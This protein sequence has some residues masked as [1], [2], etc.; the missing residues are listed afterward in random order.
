M[1]I[2]TG[3]CSA[4]LSATLFQT[5]GLVPSTIFE[6]RSEG[7]VYGYAYVRSLS[8]HSAEITLIDNANGERLTGWFFADSE[9]TADTLEFEL[10][11]DDDPRGRFSFTPGTYERRAEAVLIGKDDTAIPFELSVIAFERTEIKAVDGL[12]RAELRVPEFLDTVWLEWI[13]EP[14][15]QEA[16]VSNENFFKMMRDEAESLFGE[17]FGLP[18]SSFVSH[19]VHY[20]STDLV[21]FGVVNYEYMGGA[22]GLGVVD[23]RT[24]LIED[25]TARRIEYENLLSDPDAG[26][27]FIV[28]FC[29]EDLKSRDDENFVASGSIE[30]LSEEDVA[31]WVL[32][33]DALVVIFS[34]YAVHVYAAGVVTV[35]IPKEQILPMLRPEVQA[36][37]R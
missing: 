34:P 30:S 22:H 5:S 35:R 15:L 8:E 13:S 10:A 3:I 4:L 2:T 25:G 21:S 31:F 27:Q 9:V 6:L 12:I 29:F 17:S 11:N 28:D 23:G 14:L 37:W 1:V 33:P 18:Y 26:K 16:K 7:S 36:A 19:D 24:F 32:E 20:L